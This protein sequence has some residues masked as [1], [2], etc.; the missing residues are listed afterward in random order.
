MTTK[1][2][3][4]SV[5]RV[6][7]ARL[8][9]GAGH[10]L[11]DLALPGM[12]HVA[13]V[14]STHAHA[15]IRAIDAGRARSLSGVV[16]L[17]SHADMGRAGAPFPLLLPHHGLVALTWRA[18]AAVKARFVGEAI[19]AVVASDRYR[20]EDAAEM[21]GVEYEPLPAVVDVEKALHGGT[22]VHDEA[23][24][25]LALHLVQR[26]G[27]AAGAL[28][29]APHRFAERFRIT[30]GGGQPIETRG[31]LADWNRHSG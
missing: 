12:V 4:A 29:T 25:N 3:G 18:L 26:C 27:D 15:R 7:D 14:R 24:D 6:G 17:V 30:R 21:V 16:D 19:A 31:V 10:Y 8:V 13:L 22:A 5:R 11:D 1:L 28:A 9:T 23:P 20:A 2:F